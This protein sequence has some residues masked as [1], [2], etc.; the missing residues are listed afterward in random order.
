[1]IEPAFQTLRM[2]CRQPF[3]DTSLGSYNK[4]D[5]D[6]APAHKMDF[7]SLVCNL[8]HCQCGKVNKHYFRYGPVSGKS[9]AYCGTDYSS[10]RNRSINHSPGTIFIQKT[11]ICFEGAP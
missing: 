2:L 10:F 6:T 4:R 3:P 11:L 9:R 1:M 7:C 8:I 5:I